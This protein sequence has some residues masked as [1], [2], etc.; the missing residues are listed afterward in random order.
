MKS[1]N[2]V[3]PFL[4]IILLV[5]IIVLIAIILIK[6]TNKNLANYKNLKTSDDLVME[7]YDNYEDD[8][9]KLF[10]GKKYTADT[11][12]STY[13]FKKATK[14]MTLEDVEFKE[15]TSFIIDSEAIDSGIKTAFGPDFK[16]NIKDINGKVVT[17]FEINDKK[18]IFDVSYDAS[19]NTYVGT[20]T[21]DN[22]SSA[23]KLSKK[24]LSAYKKGDIIYLKVGYQF[25]KDNNGSY[26]LCN[27]SECNKTLD[28]VTNFEDFK[29]K[30]TILIGLKK[31]SDEVYYYSLSN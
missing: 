28:T 11:L 16:Y 18:L 29:Y 21:E 15:N 3:T 23:I 4:V 9:I 27:D 12:P 30:K 8:D 24:L 31:A 20:Y 13:I 25:Y 22:S 2:R 6:M 26:V 1:K 19:S 7:L 14:F 10:I 17:D 5:L